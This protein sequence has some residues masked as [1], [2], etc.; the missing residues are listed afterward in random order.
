MCKFVAETRPLKSDPAKAAGG[1]DVCSAAER[2]REHADWCGG[3]ADSPV[4]SV[5]ACLKRHKSTFASI[6]GSRGTIKASL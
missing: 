1:R 6:W 5:R 2:A 4:L 3:F